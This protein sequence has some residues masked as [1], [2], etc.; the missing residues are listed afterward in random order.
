[1]RH[2]RGGS[3]GLGLGG[4][5]F[6]V[7]INEGYSGSIGELNMIGD[8]LYQ[9]LGEGDDEIMRLEYYIPV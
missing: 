6:V 8:F 2:P 3:T 5:P 9:P 4:G 1:M 7:S